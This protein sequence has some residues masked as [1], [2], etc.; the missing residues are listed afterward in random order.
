VISLL[1]T[2][3]K[4]TDGH[5]GRISKTHRLAQLFLTEKTYFKQRSSP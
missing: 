4:S 3:S 1:F 5:A 2:T